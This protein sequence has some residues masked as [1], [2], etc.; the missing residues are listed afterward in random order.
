M[1]E[2]PP[3]VVDLDGTLI[4]TD[5]LLETLAGSVR[6]SPWIVLALPFWLAAGRARL[7]RE[8]GLHA[9]P[10]APQTLP[11]RVEVLQWLE[12]ERR[13]GRRVVVA[14]ASDEQ[15]ARAIATHVGVAELIASDGHTNLKG[16]RKRDALVA[17]FGER[18][19]DYAGDDRADL[20]V[21]ASARR[22]I[23]VSADARLADAA[24]RVCAETRTIPVSPVGFAPFAR[25][26][27]A[28][29]GDQIP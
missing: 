29:R 21:W 22:A 25:A 27:R 1:D 15:V 5:L 6:R 17:R 28:L 14:T 8:L 13:A 19:F 10:I 23:V 16:A 20:P 9:G 2:Q 4:K 7:K 12:A 18:G 26:L 11:Y 3:L 24:R